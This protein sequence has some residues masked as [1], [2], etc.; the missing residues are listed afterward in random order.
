MGIDEKI[1]ISAS[2]WEH[3]SG[4]SKQMYDI[5]A[6][7]WYVAPILGIPVICRKK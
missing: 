1:G 4:S 5:A 6:L 2:T 3:E 7:T